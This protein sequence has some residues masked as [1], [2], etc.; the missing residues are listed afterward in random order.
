MER[1][2]TIIRA[3]FTGL[4]F[5]MTLWW[6]FEVARRL[7]TAPQKDAEGNVVLDEYGR[8]KDILLVVLPLLTTVVGYWFGALGKEKADEKAARAEE[9]A[10]AAKAKTEAIAMVSSEPDLLARAQ[11]MYPQA[12][13]EQPETVHA[14]RE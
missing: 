3:F 7:G 8:A 11:Q 5:V 14:H 2:N 12:F 1:V 6:F 10:D 9:R 13:G 4:I